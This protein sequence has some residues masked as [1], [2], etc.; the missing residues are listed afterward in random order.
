MPPVGT[1]RI[2]KLAVEGERQEAETPPI[3]Y[4]RRPVGEPAGRCH[5]RG[6][7]G[8]GRNNRR[9][10]P[11]TGKSIGQGSRGLGRLLVDVII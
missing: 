7:S 8:D 9:M 1:G 11:D 5:A 2:R 10:I 4:A 6:Y 3:Y